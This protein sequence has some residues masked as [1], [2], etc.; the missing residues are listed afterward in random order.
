MTTREAGPQNAYFLQSRVHAS[1]Q[2]KW[3]IGP[4]STRKTY[5]MYKARRSGTNTIVFGIWC[6]KET[7][8]RHG[9]SNRALLQAP[10]LPFRPVKIEERTLQYFRTSFVKHTIAAFIFAVFAA[11]CATQSA[12]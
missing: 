6:R 9:S 12:N 10:D 7:P 1:W 2:T 11:G 5:S 3:Q 4:C 8:G